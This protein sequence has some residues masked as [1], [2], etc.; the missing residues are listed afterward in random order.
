MPDA[1]TIHIIGAGF[2][3]SIVLVLPNGKVGV[4]D[5]CSSSLQGENADER[6]QNNPT[7]RFLRKS[8]KVQQLAFLAFTHPHEDHGRGISHLLK[9]YAGHIDEIWV[10]D[11]FQE[12]ALE[13]YYLALFNSR[14]RLPIER[15]LGEEPGTFSEELLTIRKLI[16]EQIEL[17][18]TTRAFPKLFK[19]R[20]MF[21]VDGELV[22]I[23]FLGPSQ[24]LAVLY[25]E[26]IINN[27][28]GLV[29]AKGNV[30]NESWRHDTV[31]HNLASPA[32]LLTYGLTQIVVGCDM[33]VQGW[34]EAIRELPDET[35]LACQFVKV[36]HHGSETGYTDDLYAR[37][38]AQRLPLAAL[39]PFNRHRRPL[40]RRAG[41]KYLKVRTAELWTTSLQAALRSM[42]I[43]EPLSP[44]ELSRL[45][46]MIARWKTLLDAQP[47]Y[48]RS[49]DPDYVR[50][51]GPPVAGDQESVPIPSEWF[52][53]LVAEP[54]LAA[55]LHP[56][57][58][59]RDMPDFERLEP[60]E[61]NYRLSFSFDK[62]G[63]ELLEDRYV[64]PG[65]G[66]L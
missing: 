37:F 25:K 58:R 56:D 20:E 43:E 11:A 52:A 55:L 27:L 24:T 60:I 64:G 61:D 51:D 31:N 57:L 38:G 50:Q 3:E 14:R 9:E 45:G 65:C 42:G 1:I 35:S 32:L 41:V 53:D 21:S 66:K 40:P 59:I 19:G 63:N 30:L 28:A 18:N 16:I 5:C 62:D 47:Q 29:D 10:F 12:F 48:W 46:P 17:S 26:S 33:E 7:L 36:S 54:R 44:D 39:T 22:T 8:L 4:I 13:R 23:E 15:L 34:E 6:L 2:G 49:L